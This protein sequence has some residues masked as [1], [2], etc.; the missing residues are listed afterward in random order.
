M[1]ISRQATHCIKCNK[2]LTGLQKKYCSIK[3]K[4]KT[5]QYNSYEAQQKRGLKR[6]I[7]L[8]SKKGGK[9]EKCGYSNNIAA[10]Q[11]HHRDPSSK[12]FQLD[13]RSLSN[14]KEVVILKELKKCDLLCANCHLETHHPKHNIL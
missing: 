12:K 2:L 4:S 3:C 1:S 7:Q 5:H 9:C 14:R 13:M 10:L 6:K 11:F 8:I